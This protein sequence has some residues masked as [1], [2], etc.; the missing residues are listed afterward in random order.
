MINA[1]IKTLKNE[2]IRELI[3]WTSIFTINETTIKTLSYFLFFEK[4]TAS[5]AKD[6]RQIIPQD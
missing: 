6:P 3:P 2:Q 5:N 4:T 1:I